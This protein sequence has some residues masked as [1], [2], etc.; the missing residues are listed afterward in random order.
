M[1]LCESCGMPLDASSISKFDP[2]YCVYCQDQDNGKLRPYEQ[3]REGCIGAAMR[4]MSK[5]KEEAE[6]LADDMLPNLPRWKK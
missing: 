6:K 2:R 1:E 5:T 3:V 4:L